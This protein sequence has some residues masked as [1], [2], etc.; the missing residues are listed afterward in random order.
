M[1]SQMLKN[2]VTLVSGNCMLLFTTEWYQA[3]RREN[4]YVTI[5][6][7]NILVVGGGTD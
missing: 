7:L 6:Y 5:V 2:V 3:R 1:T 4:I